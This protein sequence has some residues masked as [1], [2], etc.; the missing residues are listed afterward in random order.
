MLKEIFKQKEG[1]VVAGNYVSL[2]FVQAANFILPLITLPYLVRTLGTEKFGIVMIAQA[3][4]VFLTVI[5]DFGFNISGTREVSL[6]RG[7][8]NELSQFYFNVLSIK[9]LLLLFTALLLVVLIVSFQRFRTEAAVYLLSFLMVIGQAIFPAWFFQGIE[10]MRTVTII[11][12]VAK[13]V[14]TI[15]I[16]VVV[17][18]PSDYYLVPLCHGGGFILVGVFGLWYSFKHIVPARP[19]WAQVKEIA[20]NTS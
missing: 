10:K 6:L 17:V 1:R 8:K 15:S 19:Q 5:V 16:F 12:V 14:F 2:L 18:Q 13:L 4:G 20:Q 3:L 9:I 7:K 11:N